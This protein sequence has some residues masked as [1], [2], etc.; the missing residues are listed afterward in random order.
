MRTVLFL[1][2]SSRADSLKGMSDSFRSVFNAKGYDFIQLDLRDPQCFMSTLS[3]LLSEKPIEFAFSFMN[4]GST[5]QGNDE[6][7]RKGNL[8]QGA[9]IPFL[10][11]I[12]D[13]PGYYFDLH[14]CRAPI[15]ACL[16]GFPE[17][18]VLR[19]RLPYQDIGYIGSFRSPLLD[20]LEL[21]DLDFNAKTS[22]Q[23]FFLK[24]GND[25]KQLWDSWSV[26]D[27]RP[28]NALRELASCL[29]SNLNSSAILQIDDLV[30]EFFK[31]FDLDITKMLKLRL[32][33]IAQLDDYLRRLKSTMM[34]E[35]LMDFPVQIVG[36]NWGH[37]DFIGKPVNHVDSCDY[38]ESRELIR[39]GLGVIDMS[40][41]TG[42]AP[43]DRP[44][45]AYGAHTL[46][47][48]NEQSFFS[49]DFPNHK[50]FSFSFS[51]E[52][53]RDKV[54]DVLAR[55]KHYVDVGIETAARFREV[56]P[57]EG[58]VEHLLDTAACLRLDQR[59]ARPPGFQ[60]F[61][62]WPP[63]SLAWPG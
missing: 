48:T 28:L 39:N 56:N 41:N 34:G 4:Y 2:G 54:A 37:L 21:D 29:A 18:E 35:I 23:L 49:D 58:V 22:G 9:G 46:C 14:I 27:A 8:W 30:I 60:D 12:G 32:F 55:P 13:T 11:L 6:A 7:G 3:Q 19:R 52:S 59:R 26:L 43:H 47:L 1:G 10:S 63:G 31:N 61:F 5:L 42:G 62:V 57:L 51:R 33:F 40:P 20:P 45:R 36:E 25:P 53:F 16:Y 24:N 38:T 17:H 50:E 15:H 44:C